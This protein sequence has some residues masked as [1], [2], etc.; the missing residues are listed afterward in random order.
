M[1]QGWLEGHECDMTLLTKM[2]GSRPEVDGRTV[3]DKT[4]LTGNY[5]FTLKWTP[6]ST[7]DAGSAT[8]PESLP[9]FF[10]ALQEQLGL[11]LVSAKGQVEVIVV[12]DVD[13]PSEN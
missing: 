1:G 4:G 13:E 8:G 6:K 7:T 2:L 3:V 11:R 5:D 9:S 10:T 12:D